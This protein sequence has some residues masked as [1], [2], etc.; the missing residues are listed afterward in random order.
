MRRGSTH[1]A[2]RF[3]QAPQLPPPASL[4]FVATLPPYDVAPTSPRGCVYSPTHPREEEVPPPP[5]LAQ[6]ETPQHAHC[7][8]STWRQS[9]YPHCGPPRSRVAPQCPAARQQSR[10]PGPTPAVDSAWGQTLH[11]V[12]GCYHSRIPPIMCKVA[13]KAHPSHPDPRMVECLHDPHPRS[14]LR[15]HV[16][17]L[18]LPSLRRLR[19][20]PQLPLG[21]RL[22][23]DLP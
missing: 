16:T 2:I 5:L 6:L 9:Q 15:R 18:T 17:S 4:T 19:T 21:G 23:H 20:G 13:P 14:Q 11:A 12:L 8:P 10:V 3:H 22:P 7:Q 1:I